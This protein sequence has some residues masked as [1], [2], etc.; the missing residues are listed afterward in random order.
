MI[1]IV[2]AY[3]QVTKRIESGYDW[4]RWKWRTSKDVFKNGAYF[5]P[6]GY[7][8]VTPLYGRAEWFPVSHG[9]LVPSLTS[10]AGPLRCYSGR[11]CW[12]ITHLS[13][14]TLII[15]TNMFVLFSY[16]NIEAEFLYLRCIMWILLTRDGIQISLEN[17][18]LHLLKEFLSSFVFTKT[19][20]IMYLAIKKLSCIII[21]IEVKLYHHQW[22]TYVHQGRGNCPTII[23]K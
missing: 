21:K 22:R 9:S 5:V 1:N 11:T 19:W 10:S 8:T 3:V 7:G 12:L 4:R 6:S 14:Y 2:Y 15:F 20:I 17:R 18:F 13:I 16:F 23:Y